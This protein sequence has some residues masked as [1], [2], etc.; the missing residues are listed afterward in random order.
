MKKEWENVEMYVIV[1]EENDIII[2]S[3][4]KDPGELEEED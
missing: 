2:T 4:N 1:L 3:T